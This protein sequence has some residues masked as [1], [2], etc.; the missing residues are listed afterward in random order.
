MDKLRIAFQG[1]PGAYSELAAFEH[2]G[3]DIITFPCESFEKAFDVVSSRECTYGLL[4]FENSLAGSIHRNY[5]LILRHQLHI[6]SEFHLQVNHCLLSVPDASVDEI[7]EVYSHPQALAQCEQN[8]LK[9]GA[10]RI[11]AADTAGSARLV[12]EWNQKEIAAIASTRAAEVYGLD[13]LIGNLEDNSSNFT[14]FLAL[15]PDSLE[16]KDPE[17]GDFKTSVVFSL[18]NQPGALFKAMSVFALRDID[19]TKIES[20]P[21]Q[22][23][24]WEYM[25]YVD[26]TGH[27]KAVNCK[28]A[29]DHLD[30][31]AVYLR[32]LGSYP[33]HHIH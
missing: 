4:P 26:F 7:K 5:D 6:I 13:I 18:Q 19:L 28:R 23:R 30:E 3:T 22:G 25:F 9:L 20:R 2:F 16:V 31:L 1:E 10:K 24:T 17:S 21:I 8:L 12:K 29:L 15:S 11:S 14:R 33:R 32:V 27:R